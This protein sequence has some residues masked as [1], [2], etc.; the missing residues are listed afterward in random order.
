MAVT[1]YSSSR[2]EEKKKTEGRDDRGLG[3][4]LSLLCLP[5]PS[6][7][8]SSTSSSL[9]NTS[10]SAAITDEDTLFFQLVV[11]EVLFSVLLLRC[12]LQTVVL[13]NI[14]NSSTV[15][16]WAS[17]PALVETM[18]ALLKLLQA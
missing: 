11:S 5:R 3:H 12:L 16:S 2:Q 14:F 4:L 9:G 1:A 15:F 6:P 13:V 10:N 18:A 7:Y 8:G 17:A